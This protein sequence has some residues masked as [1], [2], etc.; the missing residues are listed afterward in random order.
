ME[1]NSKDSSKKKMLELQVQ[2]S[3]TYIK[4]NL[5]GPVLKIDKD[6]NLSSQSGREVIIIRM[7]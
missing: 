4:N 2:A 1:K 5:T 7:A 6:L 3:S